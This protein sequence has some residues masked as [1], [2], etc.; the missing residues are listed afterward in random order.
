M[1]IRID[2]VIAQLQMRHINV[3]RWQHCYIVERAFCGWTVP[4]GGGG[5]WLTRVNW[6]RIHSYPS[7]INYIPTCNKLFVRIFL[8]KCI[9]I[10]WRTLGLNNCKQHC[11]HISDKRSQPCWPSNKQCLTYTKRPQHDYNMAST[12]LYS[13]AFHRVSR[14]SCA[15][16]NSSAFSISNILNFSE[17]KSQQYTERFHEVLPSCPVLLY[18][19]QLPQV[20]LWPMMHLYNADSH[21]RGP[22]INRQQFRGAQPDHDQRSLTDK[23][24]HLLGE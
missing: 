12:G 2:I 16:N 13:S 11:P 21:F 18:L 15:P 1:V 23:K 10:F 24:I 22:V 19:P 8:S 5:G 9:T 14:S 20:P 4:G 6:R 17:E 3:A 7:L